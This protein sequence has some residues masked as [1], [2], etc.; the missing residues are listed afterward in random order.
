MA[1]CLLAI[2]WLPEYPGISAAGRKGCPAGY[3]DSR[4]WWTLDHGYDGR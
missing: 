3:G 4:M 1:D 2:L